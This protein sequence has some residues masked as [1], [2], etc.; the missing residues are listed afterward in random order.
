MWGIISRSQTAAPFR[1]AVAVLAVLAVTVVT[2]LLA[3]M[4]ALVPQVALRGLEVM[5]ISAQMALL[6]QRLA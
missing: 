5:A 3:P 4:A 1:G 6:V 2:A